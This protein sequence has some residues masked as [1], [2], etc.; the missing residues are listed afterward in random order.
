LTNYIRERLT[1]AERSFRSGDILFCESL[2]EQILSSAPSNAKANELMAY[3]AGQRGDWDKAFA[4]LKRCTSGSNASAEAWY[5]LG[6]LFLKHGQCDDA[7]GAFRNSLTKGGKFF[8]G[9]HD[10]GLSFNKSGRY[11][12]ALRS[13][14][15]ALSIQP[16]SA[17]AWSNR[18][19]TLRHLR[20]YRESL[21]NLDR[22]LALAPDFAD[23]WI[24]RGLTLYRSGRYDQALESY[25]KASS[26]E[27][28]SGDIRT[29]EGTALSALRRFDEAWASYGRALALD[30]TDANAQWNE[31][32]SR[33]AAGELEAGF[34]KYESR[35]SR[36]EAERLRHAHIP[37]WL[38]KESLQGKRILVWAEQGYGDTIQFCRYVPLLAGLGAKATFEVPRALETL[39]G[40]LEGCRIVAAGGEVPEADCQIPLLSLPLAFRTKLETIPSAARY[41]KAH[42]SHVAAWAGRLGGGNGKRR[43]GIA[44]SGRETFPDNHNRSMA[45]SHFAP[46]QELGQLY[47]IQKELR[48]EDRGFLERSGGMEFPGGSVSDFHDTAAIIENL[49]LVISIDTSVAHLAAALGKPVWILLCWAP[50]WRWLV[51]RTDNPWYPSATLFRQERP[52]DWEGLMAKVGKALRPPPQ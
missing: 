33:L 20:R 6:T 36:T 32:L 27:P 17:V 23:A 29:H 18:G 43:I 4:L 42:P 26:L 48:E 46:L 7:I 13:Y 11:Q 52:G 24:N 10:L 8:E 3:V 25:R 19:V 51:D 47:V 12:E 34:E 5:H 30:P 2:L 28:D 14:D 40:S 41:L 15:E 1:L 49:D 50:D 21:E 16:Q 9:L 45:L 39:M 31:S 38:G 35:W 22:A 44:C 37:L